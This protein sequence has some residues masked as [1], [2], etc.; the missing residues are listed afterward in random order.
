MTIGPMF[1]LLSFAELLRGRAAGIITTL[2]RV[3]MFYY[4]LHIP[5]IHAAACVVSLLRDGRLDHWLLENHP[6]GQSFPPP[7]V[8]SLGQLYLVYFICLF[9]LYFPCKWYA[10]VR[11]HSRS[12]WLSYV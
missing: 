10:G 6:M 11:A 7:H 9:A 8:W 1:L 2:G 12:H 3:P 4:L 5:L